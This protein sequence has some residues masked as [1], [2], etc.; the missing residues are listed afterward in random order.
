MD[1]AESLTRSAQRL[2]LSRQSLAQE[3]SEGDISPLFRANGSTDPNDVAYVSH[4]KAGFKDWQLEVAGLVNTPLSL[5]LSE[6][7]A[8]PSRTQII[9]HDCVEGWSCIGKWTGVPLTVVL[10]RAGLSPDSRYVVFYCA[11]RLDEELGEP[12]KPSI[13]KA[14]I[15]MMPFI[16]R[17]SL[18]MR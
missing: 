9:R 4:A 5:S 10:Q 16:P 3:F 18:R 6:L 1:G 14:S 11:D 2:L 15:C 8:L 13:M 17:Q 7:R 12:S